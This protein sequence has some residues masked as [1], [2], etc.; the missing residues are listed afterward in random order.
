[1]TEYFPKNYNQY[2]EP[3]I[4]GGAIF[5][6]LLP[7]KAIISDNNPDLIN[8]YN[9][10]KDDVEN[11]IKPLKK[12]KYEKKPF[13]NLNIKTKTTHKS[14]NQKPHQPWGFAF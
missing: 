2:I 1:M 10:I 3:F 5:F 12:H 8:C 9:V 7:K 11:L 14:N 13:Q 6:H 4:G